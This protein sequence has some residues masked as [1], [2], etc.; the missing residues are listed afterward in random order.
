MSAIALAVATNAPAVLSAL[1]GPGSHSNGEPSIA[2]AVCL[3]DGSGTTPLLLAA[4]LGDGDAV[5][6]LLQ[7][8]AA[9]SIN[10][11]D[12]DDGRTALW[13]AVSAKVRGPGSAGQYAPS[14]A[15]Q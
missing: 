13:E 11:Q 10:A 12:R 6:A 3:A 2:D 9:A 7:A 8:G 5:E 4:R 1:I 15:H 14:V